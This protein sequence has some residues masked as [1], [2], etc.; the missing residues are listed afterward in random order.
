MLA[1][2]R[3]AV[4]HDHIHMAGA[5]QISICG[6]D[7]DPA[8]GI[9]GHG[10]AS[11]MISGSPQHLLNQI[12]RKRKARFLLSGTGNGRLQECAN[13]GI[14]RTSNHIVIP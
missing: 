10:A 1:P 5:D 6:R 7:I 11:M 13:L 9:V 12:P 8:C 14:G 4:C 2:A 3:V